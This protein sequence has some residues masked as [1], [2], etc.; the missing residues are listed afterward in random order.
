MAPKSKN[1]IYSKKHLARLDRERRQTRIIISVTIAVV[2]LVIGLI[3]YGLLK[4]Y[5]IKPNQPVVRVGEE[6]V[7]VREFEN[8]AR[9]NG[10]QVISGYLQN[11]QFAQLLGYDA[12]YIQSLAQQSA[13][14][15]EANTL[16]NNTLN[17]L[18]EDLLIRQEA[19]QRG[20]TV[21]DEEIEKNMQEQFGLYSDGT[22]TPEP[23]FEARPTSTLSSTQLALFP[24]TSTPT[25]SPTPE[26]TGTVEA[27]ATATELTPTATVEATT[28]P[29]ASPT[30]ALSPTPTLSPTPYTLELFQEDYKGLIEEYESSDVPES[31]IR[32]LVESGLYRQKV[33][34]AILS[35][36]DIKAEDEQVWARHILVPDEATANLILERLNNGE[37]FADLAASLSTDTGSGQNGGDLGWF[38]GGA[39]VAPFETA[40]FE[41]GIGEISQPVESSFGWHIIQ[42][43]GHEVRPLTETEYNNLETAKFQEWLDA[44]RAATEVEIFEVWREVIPVMTLPTEI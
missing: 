16:G 23:T 40:A 32:W 2:V 4:D 37:L 19:E 22:P 11:M 36:L 41:L 5:V 8:L 26:I 9:F 17:Y 29:D 44:Q 10:Q 35:E 1:T 20:M 25:Q 7:S 12:T 18:I 33:Q 27:T 28:T 34:E 14:S 42:V 21:S 24:P 3:G 43:L 15:L 30:P 13:A 6:E 31:T 39:M 38:S